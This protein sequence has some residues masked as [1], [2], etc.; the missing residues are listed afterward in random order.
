V[1]SAP[2]PDCLPHPR[3]ARASF[4]VV[5]GRHVVR[6]HVFSTLRRLRLHSHAVE[7]CR[8]RE[9]EPHLAG[10]TWGI[11]HFVDGRRTGLC[12]VVTLAVTDPHL[13]ET[14][15]H[16]SVHAALRVLARRG[17]PH[18]STTW[19]GGRRREEALAHLAG[20]LAAAINRE[21]HAR[22]LYRP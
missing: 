20:A 18:V 17:V 16:E 11:S 5:L 9:Y 14:I 22:G 13:M 8:G 6:V 15:A 21:C 3:T 19:Q 2:A 7:R 10:A 1:R 4:D 12:A